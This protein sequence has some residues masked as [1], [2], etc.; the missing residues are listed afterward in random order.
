MEFP[1][2]LRKRMMVRSYTDQPVPDDVLERVLDVVRRV[3]SAGFSQ[4]QRLVVVTDPKLRQAAG[5]I[6]DARY[7]QLGFPAWVS[8]A[9]VH[10][11]LCTR[12]SSYHERYA[13]A[14]GTPPDWPVPF[15]WYDCGALFMLLQ[16]AAINE[17]LATGFHSAVY[18]AELTPLARVVDLPDELALAGV[19]TLGYPDNSVSLPV[20]KGAVSR[21]PNDEVIDWRR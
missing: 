18:Q 6:A 21:K 10:V 16:L 17:S 19:L 13:G 11:Y 7:T 1:D 20:P 3:P 9:P 2:V 14:G 4:G 8:R 15:W 12:E 5:D